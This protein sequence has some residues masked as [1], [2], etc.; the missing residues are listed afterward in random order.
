MTYRAQPYPGSFVGTVHP[1][2]FPARNAG[3][4]SGGD[5]RCE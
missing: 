1:T 4:R 5:G 2:V 3:P